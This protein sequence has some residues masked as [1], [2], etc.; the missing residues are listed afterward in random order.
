M[1]GRITTLSTSGSYK[2]TILNAGLY[3]CAFVHAPVL[4]CEDFWTDVCHHCRSVRLFQ[5]NTLHFK[6]SAVIS[7]I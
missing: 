3:V 6:S 2:Y 5:L 7:F 1:I 4:A